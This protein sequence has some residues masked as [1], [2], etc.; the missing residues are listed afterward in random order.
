M[1]EHE[2]EQG[3]PMPTVRTF[4]AVEASADVRAAAGRLVPLLEGQSEPRAA[5]GSPDRADASKIKWV[6]PAN[7]HFTLNFLGDVPAENIDEL[8]QAAVCAAAR[9][10]QFEIEVRGAGA[11]PTTQRPRTVWLG[12]AQG[13]EPMQLLQADIERELKKLGFRGEGRDYTP[14]L[15]I[16]RVRALAR[17]DPLPSR[18]ARE[19]D[20]A[21]GTMTVAEVVVFSSQLGPAGPAYTLLKRAPLAT[22]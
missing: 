5:T 15:T 20:F 4:V 13:A 12:V 8:C 19:R 16:G 9:H 11:F 1:A 6:E 2:H 14:H 21:A 22:P 3:K 10:R 7:L 18:L 17:G